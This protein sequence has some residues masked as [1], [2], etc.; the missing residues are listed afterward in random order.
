VADHRVVRVETASLGRP[1][2]PHPVLLVLEDGRRV[3]IDRAIGNIRYGIEA[4]HVEADGRRVALRVVGP[5]PRCGFD[6]VRADAEGTT[7]DQL[8]RLVE[9]DGGPPG[10]AALFRAG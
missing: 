9:P 6:Y 7:R 2:D 10:R 4:Y 5:C 8:T 1:D 3:A